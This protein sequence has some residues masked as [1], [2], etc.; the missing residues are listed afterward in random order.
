LFLNLLCK[1]HGYI[2]MTAPHHKTSSEGVE[3]WINVQCKISYNHN[4]FG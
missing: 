4:E 2:L 3:L 1:R